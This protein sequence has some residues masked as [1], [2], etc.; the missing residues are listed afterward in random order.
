VTRTADAVVV[1]AGVVGASA[2]FQLAALGLRRV[3]L[4]E[5][6]QPGAGASGASGAFI[7]YHFCHNAPETRLTQASLPY[8]ERWDELVGAGTAGFTPCGY[9]RLEPEERAETLR[10]RV[11]MLR[12]LGV[13]SQV[14]TPDDAAR[15]APGVQMDGVAVA[16]YEPGSGYADANQTLGGLLD[17]ASQ[18]GGELLTGATVTGL[19]I[20][21]GALLGVET[22][23]GPIDTP[24]VIVAAGAWT[25]PL[26]IV[27]GLDLPLTGALTQWDSFQ[28]ASVQPDVPTIGDGVSGSYFRRAGEQVLVGLGGIARRPID[29]LDADGW[30]PRP[31]LTQLAG[32][33]LAARLTGADAARPIGAGV[34][35]ITLTP[36][37]LPIID[38]HPEIEG[39]FYFAGDC[40][41]SF[42][43]APAIGRALAEWAVLG[44][45]ESVDVSA[46]GLA[47]FGAV[48][49]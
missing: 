32:Q 15:L 31:D 20:E 22:S 3:V 14:V 39:L 28:G 44:R 5:R 9:L 19:R 6:R 41:A 33:R 36:D 10:E 7:Q 30:A 17:A 26:L 34:G 45:P 16:A 11:A 21:R 13:Y 38:R 25:E 2:F 42:K 49:A 1:G 24:I 12:E 27:V 47:R 4:C 18:R 8:F 43:T 23:A 46:F 35:P 48:D 40:G 29:A 37:D